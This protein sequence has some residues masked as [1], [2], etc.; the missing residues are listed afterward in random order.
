MQ[1][2][3]HSLRHA[4]GALVVAV[5]ARFSCC[6]RHAGTAVPA[7]Q[8]PHQGRG[9]GHRTGRPRLRVAAFPTLRRPFEGPGIDDRRH[10]YRDPLR[11][12]ALLVGAGIAAVEVET[13]GVERIGKEPV[14]LLDAP[15]AP[16]HAEP[17]AVQVRR[18]GL[19]AHDLSVTAGEVEAVDLPH[20]FRFHRINLE[21]ALVPAPVAH[22]VGRHRPVAKGR[23]GAV[24]VP[25]AGV[26]LHRP[27][28]VLGVLLALVTPR[29]GRVGGSSHTPEAGVADPG[30][31]D[32]FR[33]GGWWTPAHT[34]L[35][36]WRFVSVVRVGIEV[37][38]Y[39]P[40][41][42]PRKVGVDEFEFAGNQRILG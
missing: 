42:E 18:N 13:A 38:R 19:H 29:R 17:L 26:L 10:R 3:V 8:Q 2:S 25:L 36:P 34:G 40:I 20:R 30:S 7:F 23:H 11:L 22:G 24:P 6:L 4:R 15:R 31:T 12:R 39:Y 27:L 41:E 28:G 21:P 37:W 16:A 32:R 1:A 35:R 9:G 5:A 33:L 14:H